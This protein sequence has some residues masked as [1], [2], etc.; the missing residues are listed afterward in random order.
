[1]TNK[2]SSMIISCVFCIDGSLKSR[3]SWN[4]FGP[5]YI[6]N[7]LRALQL[8]Y[9]T[10]LLR[11]LPIL[12]TALPPAVPQSKSIS[13][14]YPFLGIHQFNQILPELLPLKTSTTSPQ[15]DIDDNF[16]SGGDQPA[17]LEA[18]VCALELLDR[19][20]TSDRNRRN[21][22][23]NRSQTQPQNV[24]HHKHLVII[25]STDI[26]PPSIQLNP[27]KINS[28]EIATEELPRT[29]TTLN[30]KPEYDGLTLQDLAGRFIQ[31]HHGNW[32][33]NDKQQIGLLERKSIILGLISVAR[34]PRL[35]SFMARHLGPLAYH[36]IRQ[37]GII[38]PLHH[39]H[40]IVISAFTDINAPNN[41][42][43][44]A[45]FSNTGSSIPYSPN[46]HL[47]GSLGSRNVSQR[48]IQDGNYQPSAKRLRTESGD[49]L[50]P[51]SN[52]FSIATST[53]QQHPSISRTSLTPIPPNVGAQ[54]GF[55]IIIPPQDQHHPINQSR[56][57]QHLTHFLS[58]HPPTTT[59]I[60]SDQALTIDDN[61]LAQGL[62]LLIGDN[63]ST[64]VPQPANT[65]PPNHSNLSPCFGPNRTPTKP[66]VQSADPT[67]QT[68]ALSQA[69]ALL[70]APQ[71][72]GR[73]TFPV[74]P[75]QPT[76]TNGSQNLAPTPLPTSPSKLTQPSPSHQQSSLNQFSTSTN[77]SNQQLSLQA[78][79]N[80]KPQPQPQNLFHPQLIQPKQQQQLQQLQQLQESHKIHNLLPNSQRP[81]HVGTSGYDPTSNNS[82]FISSPN[83]SPPTAADGPLLWKGRLIW[84]I[85]G[86]NSNT[87]NR[88]EVQKR[89]VSIPIGVVP[90]AGQSQ[91]EWL[92]SVAE[93]WPKVWTVD[94]LR[95]T[96]M[97]ELS[98]RTQTEK[99]GGVAIHLL[100]EP[101]NPSNFG[102]SN[103]NIYVKLCEKLSPATAVCAPFDDM[104]HGAV[105][106][107]NRSLRVLFGLIFQKTPIPMQIF[108]PQ[109]QQ[110]QQQ[111]Q[112]TQQNQQ[113]L[114]L[115]PSAS[116]STSTSIARPNSR[117]TVSPGVLNQTN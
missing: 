88:S 1:K 64:P 86:P 57:P 29:F 2:M 38:R 84:N 68:D 116:T 93:S 31:D 60:Q 109:S 42:R 89:E 85:P 55:P 11:L 87:I 110:N 33:L 77:Q 97:A 103:E 51:S 27:H 92:R 79:I 113:Q 17:L 39:T 101:P 53:V 30:Q 98:A 80:S 34:T 26:G 62:S 100:N 76:S 74:S 66:V 5:E 32:N 102:I 82:P 15:F 72:S 40:S 45:L 117:A 106:I 36:A 73:P 21:L 111:Q 50:A 13:R 12:F 105:I 91:N 14:P 96:L 20:P 24:L 70:I 8:L 61:S 4:S 99:P 107:F 69:L 94:A 16:D 23:R 43:P 59:S 67:P 10:A 41:K 114:G 48:I 90:C 3:I 63:K 44:A 18:I 49:D 46:S 22:N 78:G 75:N 58:S 19:K 35:L 108:I 95:P 71:P 52:S 47:I 6:N 25:S 104:G 7:Y 65:G 81:A 112:P 54:I 83:I 9:P 56:D 28:L 37:Q 115:P